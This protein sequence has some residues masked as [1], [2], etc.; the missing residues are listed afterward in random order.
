MSD[1]EINIKTCFKAY[2]EKGEQDYINLFQ[3]L[4]F[5]PPVENEE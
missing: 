2:F 5:G 4:E 3:S 1:L